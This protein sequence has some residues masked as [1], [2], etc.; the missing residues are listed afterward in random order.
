MSSLKV[1]LC[2]FQDDYHISLYVTTGFTN[3]TKVR[4]QCKLK[5]DKPTPQN[6]NLTCRTGDLNLLL[7]S[8][9]DLW[10]PCSVSA[11]DWCW[12]E[13]QLASNLKFLKDRIKWQALCGLCRI[14]PGNCVK[15]LF[16][17][18][19]LFLWLGFCKQ[20]AFYSASLESTSAAWNSS[21]GCEAKL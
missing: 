7:I 14:Q 16:F 9:T 20:R 3:T 19:F 8:P 12:D 13:N 18:F 4:R 15:D 5:I 21:Q 2:T 17:F 1:V 10:K 6:F 11:L